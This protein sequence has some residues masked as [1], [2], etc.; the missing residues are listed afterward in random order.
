MTCHGSHRYSHEEGRSIRERSIFKFVL[1]PL[2]KHG[3][4]WPFERVA[5]PACRRESNCME[6]VIVI[7]GGWISPF[8]I[9]S[10]LIFPFLL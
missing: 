8:A 5:M 3:Y 2:G 6:G 10:L 7:G 9:F 4:S 1:G